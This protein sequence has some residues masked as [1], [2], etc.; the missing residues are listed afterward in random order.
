MTANAMGSPSPSS[1]YTGVHPLYAEVPGRRIRL[2]DG[3]RADVHHGSPQYLDDH[4]R[5]VLSVG[6]LQAARAGHRLLRDYLQRKHGWR[7]KC[8]DV[9]Q[10]IYGNLSSVIQ[11]PHRARIFRW[12][13]LPCHAVPNIPF[14]TGIVSS[15]RSVVPPN[16]N[17]RMDDTV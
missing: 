4:G 11:H 5:A 3:N 12:E 15:S 16:R 6:N 9:K 1:R 7:N 13:H 8:K 17:E 2:Y 10:D 14:G